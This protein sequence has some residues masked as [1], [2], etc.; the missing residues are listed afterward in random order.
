MFLF[1]LLLNGVFLQL[2]KIRSLVIAGATNYED[3]TINLRTLELPLQTTL[4]DLRSQVVRE[5]CFTIAF[6][7]QTLGNKF[8]HAAECLLPALINLIQNS[9]KVS[10]LLN[11]KLPNVSFNTDCSDLW[12]GLR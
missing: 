6:L 12:A 8:D 7:S 2:K 5:A 11:S 3:F 1:L 4:K 9:A 10:L